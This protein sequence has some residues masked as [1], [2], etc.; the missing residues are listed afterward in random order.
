[1]LCF[2]SLKFNRNKG[3]IFLNQNYELIQGIP[4]AER[5]LL[6]RVFQSVAASGEFQGIAIQPF[7]E[8]CVPAVGCSAGGLMEGG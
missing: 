7:S 5:R 6:T 3:W 1:M 4:Y 2:V 8:K